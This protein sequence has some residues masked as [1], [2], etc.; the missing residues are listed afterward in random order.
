MN[1]PE[2]FYKNISNSYKNSSEKQETRVRSVSF[3]DSVLFVTKSDSAKDV[4]NL[5]VSLG[6]C[7]EAAIQSGLP[8]KGAILVAN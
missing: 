3:S 1:Q 7:Q 4:F 8:T 5:S 2:V 6:I